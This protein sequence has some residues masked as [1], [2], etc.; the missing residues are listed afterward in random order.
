MRLLHSLHRDELT[1]EM[2]AAGPVPMRQ[3]DQSI[4]G[5]QDSRPTRAAN[6]WRI[7]AACLSAGLCR[8]AIPPGSLWPAVLCC[9]LPLLIALWKLP[10]RHALV[11]GLLHGVVVNLFGFYWVYSALRSNI[12]LGSAASFAVFTLLILYQAGRSAAIAVALALSSR[13]GWSLWVA[14]PLVLVTTELAYPIVFPWYSG[15]FALSVPAWAQ[16]AEFGGPF[17][18]TAWIAAANAGLAEAWLHRRR[19]RRVSVRHVIGSA[20]LIAAVTLLGHVRILAIEARVERAPSVRIGVIQ[21][22]LN[23]S[24]KET[25]DP[26]A[27]YRKESSALLAREPNL[28]LLVWPEEAVYFPVRNSQLASFLRESVWRGRREWGEQSLAI[29]LLAGMLIWDDAGRASAADPRMHDA[30]VASQ[31]HNAAILTS[32]GGRIV[33]RYDKRKL[34]PIGEYSALPEWLRTKQDKPEPKYV[35]GES[36]AALLLGPYR[37]GLSICYEDILHRSFREAIL[38]SNPHLM[39]NLAA[40]SWFQRSPGPSL[41]LTLARLRAIEHR[42]FLLQVTET[43]S[44]GLVS[45]TGTII[46]SLPEDERTHGAVSARWLDIPTWYQR[47]GDW[48]WCLAVILLA[49]TLFARPP[50]SVKTQEPSSASHCA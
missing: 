46:W 14:F 29:P 32:R 23:P 36:N 45:P 49:W 10:W 24:R 6:L 25:R 33:G 22:N 4:G 11:I 27:V 42:K 39:I 7:G 17:L 26:V 34:M 8:L 12:E 16:L 18:L 28:D 21:G 20:V 38:E 35:T 1:A 43:G 40:D 19:P 37:L 31:L 30:A 2:L 15:H 50:W 44:T 13:R 5:I 47:L 48:P 3:D 41:H 9:W